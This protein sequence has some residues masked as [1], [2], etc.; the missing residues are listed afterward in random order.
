MTDTDTADALARLTALS[1]DGDGTE[2]VVLTDWTVGSD[3][4]LHIPQDKREKYGIEEG[5]DIDAVLAV[6]EE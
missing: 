6:A 3:G 5:D 2:M 1:G 4:R